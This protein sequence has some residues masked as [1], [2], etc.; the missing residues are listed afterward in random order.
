MDPN[1][2]IAYLNLGEAYLELGKKPEAKQALQRYL[3]LQPN[4][5]AAPGAMEKL[6]NLQ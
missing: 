6:K 4:S 5:K 1:R 2:A 3:E